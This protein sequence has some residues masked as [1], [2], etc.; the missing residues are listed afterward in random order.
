[1]RFDEGLIDSVVFLTVRNIGH[2]REEYTP[3]GTGF[4]VTAFGGAEPTFYYLV[5]A[6]HVVR[7]VDDVF[8]R[9]RGREGEVEDLLAGDWTF[10]EDPYVDVAV[11]LFTYPRDTSRYYPINFRLDLDHYYQDAW[12]RIGDR[13]YY[14]GL[15]ERVEEM[16]RQGTPFVR[17]GTIG[18]VNQK[19]IRLRT[20]HSDSVYAT[21]HLV[22]CHGY[23]GFSGAPVFA[24]QQDFKQDSLKIDTD[25]MGGRNMF[26]DSYCEKTFVKMEERIVP[27]GLFSGHFDEK[28]TFVPKGD[29]SHDWP[30]YEGPGN[31]GIG[32]V[33]P[34]RF[35]YEVLTREEL[36]KDRQERAKAAQEEDDEEAATMDTVRSG[37]QPERL[38]LDED[39]EGAVDWA[40]KKRKPEEGWP[41][42]G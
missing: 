32:V 9:L 37:P 7:Y 1:M 24:H 39:F 41:D 38:E 13:F 5:T 27:C 25:L 30:A 34:M 8:V 26:G 29:S 20:P 31:L 16:A 12:P 28:Q 35:I 10:H 19:R 2:S 17:T 11:S 36:V 33:T 18:A 4:I 23:A 42:D 40:L 3:I 22:E 14:I 21:G 6:A 15:L